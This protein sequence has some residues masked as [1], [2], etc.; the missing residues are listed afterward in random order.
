M[1][2]KII[3]GLDLSL[4]CSGIAYTKTGFRKE[5]Y[6]HINIKT[7]PDETRYERA[8]KISEEMF[9]FLDLKPKEKRYVYFFFE[10]YAYGAKSG[11]NSLAYQG[12]LCGILKSQ[13]M[14]RCQT[15]MIPVS[16]GTWKK[17]LSNNG[18][19]KKDEFKLQIYK[20]FGIECKTNDEAAAIGVAYFGF[21]IITGDNYLLE[22]QKNILK[23]YLKN[24]PK[25]LNN[26]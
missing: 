10:D 11:E 2:K 16:I 8:I 7:N 18:A 13:I 12:E 20:R 23:K 9:L 5:D 24:P 15:Q 6:R 26:E 21:H 3:V 4:S 22:Y 14:A 19:L 25:E 17:F 1:S